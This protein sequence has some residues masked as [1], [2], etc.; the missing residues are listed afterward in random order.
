MTSTPELRRKWR[1]YHEA[2]AAQHAEW[3]ARDY[4][5]PAPAAIPYPSELDGLTCGAKTRAGTPCKRRDLYLSGRCRLH[6]GLSTGPKSKALTP[7]GEQD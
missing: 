7:C 3:A 6:G 4:C 5:H 1:Q 2:T